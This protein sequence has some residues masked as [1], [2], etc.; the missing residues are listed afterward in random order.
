MTQQPVR[1]F[2]DECLSKP[3][4]ESQITPS[5][6]LYGSDAEVAHLF[7]KFEPQTADSVWIPKL[8]DEGGWIVIS[9][10]RGIN[11]KKSEKLPLIC[12]SLGVSHV[13]LSAKLHSRN[14]YTKAIAI[15]ASWDGLIAIG[16][17]PLGS[18]YLLHLTGRGHNFKLKPL[19]DS[20][21]PED[22]TKQKKLFETD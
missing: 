12:K 16:S 5:L 1:F 15:E 9:A 4:V 14:M 8:A 20:P 17:A 19:G 22:V 11:S 21:H 2:F 13:L 6:R 3:I 18:G 10:D 7:S